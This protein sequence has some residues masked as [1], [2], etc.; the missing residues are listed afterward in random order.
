VEPPDREHVRRVPTGDIDDV[1]VEQEALDV[2]D[3]PPEQVEVA[4]LRAP[5]EGGVEVREAGRALAGRRG[6]HAD[7]WPLAAREV[8]HEL[9]QRPV[10][11]AGVELDAADR[12]DALRPLGHSSTRA[13]S[14]TLG[15]RSR[16][17]M[18]T[19]STNRTVLV[20]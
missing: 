5:R 15:G 12:E 2:V 18:W 9:V 7:P 1:L 11:G 8:Q 3:R 17:N 16:S 14:R 6:E 10:G 13:Y 20:W 19:V 4:R